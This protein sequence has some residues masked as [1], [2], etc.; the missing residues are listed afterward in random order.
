MYTAGGMDVRRREVESGMT[1]PT[2]E[3]ASAF[4]APGGWTA[5]TRAGRAGRSPGRACSF[6]PCRAKTCLPSVATSQEWKSPALSLKVQRRA[7]VF[8]S[9]AWTPPCLSRSVAP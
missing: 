7:P 6:F 2:P 9:M 1:R 3:N 8:A 4:P 5:V